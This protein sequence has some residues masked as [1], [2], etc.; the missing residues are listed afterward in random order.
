MRTSFESPV[1]ERASDRVAMQHASLSGGALDLL[2][3]RGLTRP[4]P[5]HFHD[6]F[7]L[8]VVEQGTHLLRTRRGEWLAVAGDVIAL[9]PGE[10]HAVE[11]VT[12]GGYGYS[13][14]YPSAG[15]L[16]PLAG[17]AGFTT[18][19]LADPDI[20][21]QLRAAHRRLRGEPGPRDGESLLVD[22]TRSLVG[23]HA[24]TGAEVP[25][26]DAGTIEAVGRARAMIEARFTETLRIATIASACGLKPLQ[27][28]RSFRQ[29]TGIPPYAYLLQLRVNLAQTLLHEG[30]SVADVAYRCGFSDQSHLSRSF[31]R[32]VGVPPGRY[33]AARTRAMRAGN[34]LGEAP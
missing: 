11:P 12:A 31:K 19:V 4:F 18:P 15:L 27:M 26:L 1:A 9:A 6:T 14:L 23:R 2:S 13:M 3:V 10:V 32:V 22:A 5:A 7:A 28:I 17:T 16:E 24:R 25:E 8:G 33:G 34:V 21:R 30:Q 29:V 20:A